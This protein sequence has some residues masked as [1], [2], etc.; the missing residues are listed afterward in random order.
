MLRR[1]SKA[2]ERSASRS[3]SVADTEA[4]KAIKAVGDRNPTPDTENL[5]AG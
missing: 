4:V 1:G 5:A 3:V 2:I